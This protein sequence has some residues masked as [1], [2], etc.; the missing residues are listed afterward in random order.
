MEL[1]NRTVLPSA[2]RVV[3]SSDGKD[4]LHVAIKATYSFGS[5]VPPALSSVQLPVALEDEYYGDPSDSALRYSSDFSAQKDST[6][7]GLVGDAVAA[8][9]TISQM[10][11]SL[12][13]GDW[14]RSLL[15]FGDRVW[16]KK[17]GFCR[18]TDP[19]VF[20]SI[21]LVYERAFGGGCDGELDARN[22]IG[23]GFQPKKSKLPISEL[24]V[25][26]IETSSDPIKSRKDCPVPAGFGFLNPRW[27]QKT[28]A[29]AAHPD[30][31]YGGFLKGNEPIVLKGF[32]EEGDFSF[33]L[34]AQ[35]PECELSYTGAESESMELVVE[36]LFIDTN[37]QQ[38]VLVWNGW[39]DISNRLYNL[40]TIDVRI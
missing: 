5:D 32:S 36:K 8:S 31:V 15:I 33:C 30:L 16:K 37:E 18:L 4:L 20:Q 28:P 38:A 26:H 21:P 29:Q 19:A 12:S 3:K 13:I 35:V 39:K 11:V 6:D 34:P 23:V 17:L 14:E 1:V 9:D 27:R 7:I 40:E 2:Y 24:L 10:D 22:P 25:P